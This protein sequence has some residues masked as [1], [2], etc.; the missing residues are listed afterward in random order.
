MAAA[1]LCVATLNG[2]AQFVVEM[3]DGQLQDWKSLNINRQGEDDVWSIGQTAGAYSEANDLSRVKCISVKPLADRLA[4]YEAPAYV[5][6]YV[7][8]T[9]W[10]KRSQWNLS[11]V[12]DPTVMRADDGY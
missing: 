5:D 10:N 11:N 9:D 4:G 8:L 1:A 6:N 2:Q 7:N 3:N 12:H